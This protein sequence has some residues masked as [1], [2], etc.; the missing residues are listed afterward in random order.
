MAT[1]AARLKGKN[2]WEEKKNQ[3]DS[4]RPSHGRTWLLALLESAKD[5]ETVPRPRKYGRIN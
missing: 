2:P 3:L 4:H 1:E 5:D